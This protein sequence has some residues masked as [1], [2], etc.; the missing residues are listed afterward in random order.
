MKSIDIL[1]DLQKTAASN[2]Q[3]LVSAVT[4][5][6][7][8]VHNAMATHALEDEQRFGSIDRRLA[9]VESLRTTIR[10]AAGTIVVAGLAVLGDLL[11]HALR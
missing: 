3:D 5:G 9:P 4:K 7:E 2:H 8:G 6:F 10:W 11:L 1:L